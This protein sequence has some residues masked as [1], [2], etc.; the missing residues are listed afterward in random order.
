MLREADF[1]ARAEELCRP[2]YARGKGRPS[3]AP[4]VYFRML[5]IG[6][7]VGDRFG[8]WDRMALRGFARAAVLPGL[9][10]G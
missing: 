5:L 3:V 7:F 4:G 2:F 8:A 1:D 6:Y 10:A 9:R